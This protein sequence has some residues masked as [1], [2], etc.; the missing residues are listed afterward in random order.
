MSNHESFKIGQRKKSDNSDLRV[1]EVMQNRNDEISKLGIF[2]RK[3][4]GGKRKA[5]TSV[6]EKGLFKKLMKS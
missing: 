4:F 5:K 3:G 6:D 2:S 1:K